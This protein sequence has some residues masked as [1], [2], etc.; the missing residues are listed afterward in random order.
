VQTSVSE[1]GFID[2]LSE[3]LESLLA[4]RDRTARASPRA[5]CCRPYGV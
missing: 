3:V 2:D 4:R 5:P 1:K